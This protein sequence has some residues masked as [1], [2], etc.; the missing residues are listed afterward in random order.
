MRTARNPLL[1]FGPGLCLGPCLVEQIMKLP[2]SHLRER[3]ISKLLWSTNT[4]LVRAVLSRV[5]C[6]VGRQP[7]YF[8]LVAALHKGSGQDRGIPWGGGPGVLHGIRWLLLGKALKTSSGTQQAVLMQLKHWNSDPNR[9]P[10]Q[11]APHPPTPRPKIPGG[12]QILDPVTGVPTSGPAGTP[13]L[14]GSVTSPPRMSPRS[15]CH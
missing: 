4:L 8:Y 12:C 10:S 2:M 13:H 14:Q 9:R 3:A 11:E 6:L 1:M 15:S 5:L 7:P